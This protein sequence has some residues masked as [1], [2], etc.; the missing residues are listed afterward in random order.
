MIYSFFFKNSEGIGGV[1][2]LIRNFK[3]LAIR[4]DSKI[5]EVYYSKYKN[6]ELILVP[7]CSRF[8]FLSKIFD[9]FSPVTKRISAYLF[10]RKKIKNG[11]S[12]ILYQP[13]DLLVIP[14]KA[15]IILIQ[16]NKFDFLFKFPYGL[17]FKKQT[18]KINYF[19]VYTDIDKEK[20]ISLFPKLKDKIRIIP[21]GCKIQTRCEISTMSKKLVTICRIEE[22][23][24]NFSGMIEIMKL[25]PEEYS[26][27]IYGDGAVEEVSRLKNKIANIDNI[28]YMGKTTD[29]ASV[30]INYSIF[31]MTSNYE[32][33]GQSLIEARSQGLPIIVYNTF[34]AARWI[35]RDGENGYLISPR[36]SDEYC[37]KIMELCTND[38]QYCE[39][40]RR[41]LELAKDTELEEIDNMWANLLY[42]N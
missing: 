13:K 12:V 26:L 9:F 24:K 19:C 21:R 28:R 20:L 36:R 37:S 31:I 22:E 7:T 27:D 42:N 18:D 39:F 41:S 33:F 11:D 15:N 6:D 29:V 30:L 3:D 16:T 17:I 10:F 38:R 4:L 23:Q 25:L 40:S 5:E 34:D 1:E 35:V 2:Q 14:N 32:G 8:S